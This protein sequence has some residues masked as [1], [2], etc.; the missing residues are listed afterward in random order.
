MN[1]WSCLRAVGR[2]WDD[3]EVLVE[4]WTCTGNLPGVCWM[5]SRRPVAFTGAISARMGTR[6]DGMGC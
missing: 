4:T 6:A 2:V 1:G 3:R 5:R